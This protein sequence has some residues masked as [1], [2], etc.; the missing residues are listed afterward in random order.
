MSKDIKF[1][2]KIKITSKDFYEGCEAVVT[3]AQV[4]DGKIHKVTAQVLLQGS[5]HTELSLKV[6]NFVKVKGDK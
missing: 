1:G 6:G 3:R 5:P 2:D 4:R